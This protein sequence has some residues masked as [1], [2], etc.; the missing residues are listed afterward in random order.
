M[1][2]AYEYL[3]ARK[4]ADGGKVHSGVPEV[5]RPA[6]V[7]WNQHKVPVRYADSGPVLAYAGPVVAP[8]GPENIHGFG[9]CQR[10]VQIADRK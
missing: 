4:F 3:D 7:P 6:D 1:V 5:H 9:L 10:Q 2:P 8:V